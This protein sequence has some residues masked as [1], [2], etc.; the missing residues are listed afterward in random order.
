MKRRSYRPWTDK[1]IEYL[2]NNYMN[3][4]IRELMYN[5]NRS[6]NSI[7]EKA[8]KLNMPK[9]SFYWTDKEFE[10]LKNNY[11]N[12]DIDLIK[13]NLNR[14]TWRS[15]RSTAY[16]LGLRRKFRSGLSINE[17]FLKN[18]TK[19]MAWTFGL[20]IADGDMSKN[21]NQIS[22]TSK[23][24]DLLETV[25]SNLESDHK[26]LKEKNNIYR[27]KFCNKTIYNDLLNRG[28]TP[29]KS[30][31]IQFPE[32]PDEFLPD[33]IRGEFDGDG[34]NY[35]YKN[36]YLVS[37]FCGN[38]N[39]LSTLKDKIEK[40]ANIETGKLYSDKRCDQR[41]RQLI[42]ND[43]KAIALCDY[44]YQDS[45]NLRLERK[46]K[47]YYKMKHEYIKKLNGKEK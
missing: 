27:F 32:V 16:S 11:S 5:L 23:D 9:K 25:K 22:F 38:M 37:G 31:T 43:K 21:S 14:H 42:Y 24:C 28:G 41:V 3:L 4:S 15:I 45:E 33:F 2:K 35:I 47:I 40:H 26:I 29:A 17:D 7:R 19:E 20:W 34:Y 13:L 46:F 44:I 12:A 10:F 6:E 1:E 36:K 18:W 39:F 8:Y 30:L